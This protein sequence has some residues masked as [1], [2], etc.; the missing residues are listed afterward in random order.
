MAKKIKKLIE[1]RK[2]LFDFASFFLDGFLP[3]DHPILLNPKKRQ[4]LR[5]YIGLSFFISLLIFIYFMVIINI[6]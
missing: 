2:T 4:R 1:K 6:N 3:E 5:I